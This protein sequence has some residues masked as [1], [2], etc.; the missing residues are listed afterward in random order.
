[1]SGSGRPRHLFFSYSTQYVQNTEQIDRSIPHARGCKR[2][3][4]KQ[5][6]N[7]LELINTIITVITFAAGLSLWPTAKAH[8]SR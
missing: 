4:G 1:M 8:F 3:R 6:E 7:L 5:G 2:G